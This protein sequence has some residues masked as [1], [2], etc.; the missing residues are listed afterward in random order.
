MKKLPSILLTLLTIALAVVWMSCDSSSTPSISSQFAFIRE[1]GGATRTAL[2]AAERHYASEHMREFVQARKL[3]RSGTGLKPMDVT[4]ANGTDSIVL[5]NNDGTGEN[6]IANQAGWFYSVHLAPDGKKGVVVAEDANGV[7]QVYYV[8]LTNLNDPILTQLTNDNEWHWSAQI[9]WDGRKV[10]FVTYPAGSDYDQITTVTY[11]GSSWGPETVITT[12]FDAE[13][14]T[15]TPS[16]QLVLE[17]DD[18][19]TIVLMNADGTGLKEITKASDSE[20]YD[21]TPSVS[22]DGKTILFERDSM[23]SPY[24]YYIC[25]VPV[26]GGTVTKLTTSGYSGDPMYAGTQIVYASYLENFS[27]LEIFSMNT[28]GSNQKQLT[29]NTVYEYFDYWWRD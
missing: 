12:N 4:I 2:S 7:G 21:W 10:V 11:S 15:F 16:G 26:A 8:D 3:Q 18:D 29:N 14:P 17:N 25:T 19:D 5:M 6:V 24:E 27:K 9:S 22:A 28:D 13:S 20:T 1:A 23:T